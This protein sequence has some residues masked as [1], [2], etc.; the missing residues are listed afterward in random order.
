M[1]KLLFLRK[2]LLNQKGQF[3]IFDLLLSDIFLFL[4]L[5]FLVLFIQTVDKFS[6][7]LFF[8]NQLIDLLLILLPQQI[9][10][11]ISK[12]FFLFITYFHE[13]LCLSRQGLNLIVLRIQLLL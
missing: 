1:Q 12:L 13:M 3:V 11:K 6:Y 9:D 4:I 5:E 8:L 2:S 10:V 7:F